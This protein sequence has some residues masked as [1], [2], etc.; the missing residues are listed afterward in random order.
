MSFVVNAGAKAPFGGQSMQE[1]LDRLNF[2]REKDHFVMDAL[3]WGVFM[4]SARWYCDKPHKE[5]LRKKLYGVAD[6]VGQQTLICTASFDRPG[7]KGR[8]KGVGV[9]FNP[10]AGKLFASRGRIC[11]FLAAQYMSEKA[12]LASLTTAVKQKETGFYWDHSDALPEV[13]YVHPYAD[14]DIQVDKGECKFSD[15]FGPV[16]ELIK[17]MDAFC[18]E[19]GAVEHV[20]VLILMNNRQMK[21]GKTEKWSFHIHWPEIVMANVTNLQALMLSFNNDV[22]RQPNGTFLVDTKTYSSSNQLFRMPYCGKMGDSGAVLLPINPS[23]IVGKGW[24]FV[25]S[26]QAPW[27]VLN[28]SC[29]FTNTPTAYVDVVCT[30]VHRSI[31]L[32]V[33][34]P[35]G[36]VEK[37]DEDVNEYARWMNFWYPVL[38]EFVIPSFI[39]FRQVNAKMMGVV[40]SFPSDKPVGRKMLRLAD[41]PCSFRVEVEGDTYCEYDHGAT[42]FVHSYNSNAT[43][44]VVDLKSGRICQ[45]CNKC[46]GYVKKWYNF[47]TAGKLTFEILD[48]K[49]ME[50]E[51]SAIV[52][53]K[54]NTNIIPFVLHFFRDSILYVKSTRE[55]MAYNKDTC[56]WVSGDEGNSI[57]LQKINELNAV[58]GEYLMA[59]NIQIK[60]ATMA[61]WL[62]TNPREQVGGIQYQEFEEKQVELCRNANDKNGV[63]WSLSIP[64]RC[65][66]LKALKPDFHPHAVDEMEPFPHLVPLNDGMCVDVYTFTTRSMVSTDYFVGH[67][68]AKLLSLFD[69]QVVDF[70]KWQEML[71]CGDPA[72]VEYKLRIMGLSL[73]L[74]DFDRAF[75][76]PLG[77]SGRNGKSSES[78]LFDKICI[79]TNPARGYYLPREY[80]TQGGQNR[81]G[82]NAP[83]TALIEM[84]HKCVLIADECRDVL[85]DTTLIKTMVSG[86]KASGRNLY[87]TQ[88]SVVSCQGKLWIIANNTLKLDYGDSA[89]MDRLRILPYSAMWVNDPEEAKAKMTDV[90]KKMWVFKNDSYFK[91]KVLSMWG[92]AMVTTCIY[93]LHLFFAGLPRDPDNVQRPLKLETI[94]APPAVVAFTKEVIARENPVAMFVQKFMATTKGDEEWALLDNVFANYQRLGRNVNSTRMKNMDRSKFTETLLKQGVYVVEDENFVS[95]VSG[96]KMAREVPILCA[97]DAN[98]AAV[99]GLS[100]IPGPYDNAVAESRKR[101]RNDEYEEIY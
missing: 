47:I 77:T 81:K 12:G 3:M 22:P 55:V 63:I 56:V 49:Q 52:I 100:Y 78:F 40:C 69:Q 89:L 98:G 62:V 15:V 58:Y 21:D 28:D 29:T 53:V 32:K 76:V 35:R 50:C 19:K 83:D 91:E 94:K 79:S 96:Y 8:G 44:Y 84:Q 67:L 64:Q 95:R 36:V 45:Q 10:R 70:K 26:K 2:V 66:V 88:R 24:H 38:R 14:I 60:I 17:L 82:N 46:R 43:S 59:R 27:S 51:S 54:K 1:L 31:G 86:D 30:S 18:K 11:E 68:N 23:N 7:F 42:K 41:W 61:E 71:C 39:K 85:L 80:L 9:V 74:L 16:F 6:K 99:E 75:Y 73:T 92:D 20:K 48:T 87:E 4:T 33:V 93:A 97:S 57:V 101:V 65:T 34:R 13:L 72:Y 90:S 37:V 5:F 25:E